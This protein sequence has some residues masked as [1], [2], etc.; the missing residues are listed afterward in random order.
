MHPKHLF[1]LI[2]IANAGENVGENQPCPNKTLAETECVHIFNLS[3]ICPYYYNDNKIYND[4]IDHIC[5]ISK[6]SLNPIRVR[7]ISNRYLKIAAETC[8]ADL[9]EIDENL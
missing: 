7:G 2:T 9:S 3:V 8:G 5:L 4:C 1:F 6:K